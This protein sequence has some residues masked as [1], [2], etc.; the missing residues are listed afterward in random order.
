MEVTAILPFPKSLS[1]NS[2]W[3]RSSTGIYKNPKAKAYVKEVWA[4]MFNTYRFNAVPIRIEV[5]MYPPTAKWDIDNI[6][7][8]LLDSLQYAG[9]YDN[10]SQVMQL[11][12]EKLPP[13]KD[14]RLVIKISCLK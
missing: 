4:I 11:Y 10:D 12:V 7:K 2:V 6:L 14:S 1:V 9:V 5:K 13:T 3:K 8:V